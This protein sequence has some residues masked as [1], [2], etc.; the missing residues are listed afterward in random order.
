MIYSACFLQHRTCWARLPRSAMLR[1]TECERALVGLTGADQT[2]PR[3]PPVSCLR[4]LDCRRQQTGSGCESGYLVALTFPLRLLGDRN[5][6][7]TV[8][9]GRDCVLSGTSCMISIWAYTA[10]V[11]PTQALRRTSTTTSR[12]HGCIHTEVH[13]RNKTVNKTPT[14]P[15]FPL[16]CSRPL[17][18][19][20]AHQQ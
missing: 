16:T 20:V 9:R 5:T 1:K 10:C 3:T 6:V 11:F 4:V 17:E 15:P 18:T 2:I 12:E 7:T 13:P 8:S 19:L 14:T